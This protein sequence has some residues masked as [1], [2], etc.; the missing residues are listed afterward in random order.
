[1]KSLT[2]PTA[3]LLAAVLFPQGVLLSQE[4]ELVISKEPTPSEAESLEMDEQ[5]RLTDDETAS[6][7]IELKSLEESI[8]DDTRSS[9][10]TALSSLRSAAAS[11]KAA[12]AY[13]L[14]CKEQVEFT[15]NGLSSNDFRPVK[16]R[17]DNRYKEQKYLMEALRFQAEYLILS[18]RVSEAEKP[19]S[20]HS[21]LKTFLAKVVRYASTLEGGI[22]ADDVGGGRPIDPSG[23]TQ[24]EKREIAEGGKRR[25]GGPANEMREFLRVLNQAVTDTVFA[26][27]HGLDK[28]LKVENWSMSPSD[29]T[30]IFDNTLLSYARAKDP[31]KLAA[32]WDDRI[33][34][35]SYLKK[36]SLDPARYNEYIRVEYPQM[37]FE[38]A[39]DIF[40]Y[41]SEKQGIAAMLKLIRDNPKHPAS[42]NW[43]EELRNTVLS[44][45]EAGNAEI[46]SAE[47]GA[48]S[49]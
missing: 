33:K 29:F 10:G 35:T 17:L 12:Y 23:L 26:K 16:E 8:R 24:K 28:S 3:A 47:P 31:D 44:T 32:T 37:S 38:K 2:L 39:R 4:G 34:Y 48:P 18:I 27:A 13:F 7:L 14:N 41:K 5:E 20:V 36:A 22:G 9:R 6:L 42:I 46:P 11:D 19:E 25:G 30:G 1:M 15:R 45:F 43:V 21:D 40:S 49:E